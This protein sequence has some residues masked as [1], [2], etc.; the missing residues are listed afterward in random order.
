MAACCGEAS[1]DAACC[2]VA[3]L[4]C[5]MLWSCDGEAYCIVAGGEQPVKVLLDM[6][7]SVVRGGWSALATLIFRQI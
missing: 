5:S 3:L 1:H 2:G 4:W 7:Q 6:V